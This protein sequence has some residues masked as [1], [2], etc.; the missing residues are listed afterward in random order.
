MNIDSSNFRDKALAQVTIGYDWSQSSNYALISVQDNEGAIN[1]YRLGGLTE[2][3]I[4]DDFGCMAA[5]SLRIRREY[6]LA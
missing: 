1:T 2:Y 6:T 5:N 3:S 4:S